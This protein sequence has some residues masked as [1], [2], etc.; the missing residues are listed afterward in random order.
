MVSLKLA[1]PLLKLIGEG[2]TIF[3]TGVTGVT[4]PR[5]SFIEKAWRGDSLFS[6]VCNI[7]SYISRIL[8]SSGSTRAGDTVTPY[9]Y[10]S[11]GFRRSHPR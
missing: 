2:D 9:C 11:R 6:G 1:D 7:L 8:Y 5:G 10:T 4:K 3:Y